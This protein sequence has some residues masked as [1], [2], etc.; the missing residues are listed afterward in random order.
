MTAFYEKLLDEGRRILHLHFDYIE[1]TRDGRLLTDEHE[2]MITAIPGYLA[3]RKITSA[4]HID[5]YR[6]INACQF[7]TDQFLE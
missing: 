4:S 7:L 6:R 3:W 1:R 5:P 2:D